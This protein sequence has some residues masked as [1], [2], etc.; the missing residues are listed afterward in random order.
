MKKV[1]DNVLW[2]LDEEWS[3]NPDKEVPPGKDTLVTTTSWQ[4]LIMSLHDFKHRTIIRPAVVPT[5]SI[6]DRKER[7]V[8]W[9]GN[10][11]DGSL[12]F[13]TAVVDG[14]RRSGVKLALSALPDKPVGPEVMD[15]IGQDDK[16]EVGEVNDLKL[17]REL[18]T[19][20]VYAAPGLIPFSF[21]RNAA[22]AA[23]LGCTVVAPRKFG[24]AEMFGNIGGMLVIY[25]ADPSEYAMAFASGIA[26]A[27][28][29]ANDLATSVAG[30]SLRYFGEDQER[31]SWEELVGYL[32]VVNAL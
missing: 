13:L 5:I 2:A 29:T 31:A 28:E 25:S 32:R 26:A 4:D 1:P 18:A 9:A 27:L 14:L 17:Q 15:H 12:A 22:M 20:S 30:V 19:A 6:A 10:P 11:A 24:Y 3:R 7:K 21:D 16:V 23:C 8:V